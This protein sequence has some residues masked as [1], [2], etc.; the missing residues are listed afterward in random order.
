MAAVAATTRASVRAAAR[1]A[2]VHKFSKFIHGSAT[3]LPDL[4]QAVPYWVD[5]ES[6]RPSMLQSAPA[7]PPACA[8]RPSTP[9]ARRGPEPPGPAGA[10]PGAEGCL[11]AL[12]A[13][14]G[15]RAGPCA[16]ARLRRAACAGRRG[17]FRALVCGA[18]SALLAAPARAAVGP[19][20]V[21][22]QP[23]LRAKRMAPR[24][25]LSR[26]CK[27]TWIR[28]RVGERAGARYCRGQGAARAR[29]LRLRRPRRCSPSRGGAPATTRMSCAT[30]C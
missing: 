23:A 4:V 30:R 5:D 7:A 15:Q 1:R 2:Q 18:G 25:G 27:G 8:P 13:Q 24:C 20:W 6:V 29:P 16:A 10:R 12:P 22:S 14:P 11:A 3:L 28:G 26:A 17:A 19:S 21:C 9:A